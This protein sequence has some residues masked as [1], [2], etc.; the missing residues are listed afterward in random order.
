MVDWPLLAGGI[1]AIV[2]PLALLMFSYS[3]YDGHFKDNVLFLFF[4]GGLFGGMGLAFLE[5]LLRLPQGTPY[6]TLAMVV[7]G[8]PVLEQTLKLVALN[9]KKYQGERTTIFYGGALGLGLATMLVLVKSQAPYEVPLRALPLGEPGNV[10]TGGLHFAPFL[11]VVGV[12]L[13]LVQFATGL[14]LGEGVRARALRR[15]LPLAIGAGVPLQLLAY[16]FTAHLSFCRV[17]EGLLYLPLMLAYAGALGWWAH[18]RLLPRALPP[19]ARR[20]RRRALLRER[21]AGAGREP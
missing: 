10:C 20:K 8:Y 6:Y 16:Q 3:P 15:A 17:T 9:R 7:L 4:M 14:L 5:L 19:D 18:T 12:S 2:P 1:I 21:R 13:A 11:V